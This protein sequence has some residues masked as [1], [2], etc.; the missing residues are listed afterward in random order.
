MHA[1][2][3][4]AGFLALSTGVAC[5]HLAPAAGSEIPLRVMTYNIRSGNGNLAGTAAAIRA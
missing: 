5:A 1:L 2:F 4:L 3:R